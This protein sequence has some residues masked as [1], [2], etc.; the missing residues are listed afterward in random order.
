M[1]TT[2]R[3]IPIQY[4]GL[5]K[6]YGK[7]DLVLPAIGKCIEVI[8]AYGSGDLAF[9]CPLGVLCERKRYIK[10]LHALLADFTFVTGYIFSG[11]EFGDVAAQKAIAFTVWH[12]E[13]GASTDLLD[14]TFHYQDQ[15]IG[16]QRTPL[17]KEGWRYRDGVK[18]ILNKDRPMICAPNN[19]FFNHPA[20]KLI[21]HYV[22]EGMGAYIDPANV[23]IP[24]HL[25]Y[26][27]EIVYGLWSVT[28]GSH[29]VCGYPLVF[30]NCY[31]HL[32]DFTRR[33]TI[34]ILALVALS[35]VAAELRSPHSE[36]QIGIDRRG[37]VRFGEY[38]DDIRRL[39]TDCGNITTDEGATIIEWLGKVTSEEYPRV[40]QSVADRL[41][42]IGYWRALS[43]PVHESELE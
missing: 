16:F 15:L 4:F 36:G 3:R 14:L 38:T 21:G 28:V 13:E 29:A 30:D 25:P 17:L 6:R 42:A 32:P 11:A 40:K 33:E 5:D 26:R 41:E 7:G 22:V 43:L 18:Y 8:K 12:Y 1:E 27:D 37:S 10:L 19:C 35:V 2:T 9:F 20:P 24:L 31:V 23:K 39:L 34:E